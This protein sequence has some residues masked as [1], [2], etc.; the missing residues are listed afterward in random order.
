[1]KLSKYKD[2][3]YDATRSVSSVARTAAFAGIALIWVFRVEGD[4][5]PVIP[6]ALVAPAALLALGLAFDLLQYILAA[7]IWGWFYRH[8]EKKLESPNDD[9][10]ISHPPWYS[11]P[12]RWAFRA[13]V[14]AIMFGYFLVTVYVWRVWFEG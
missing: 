10:D 5:G 7:T 11:L 6:R 14:A 12:I 13:K 3:Y 1:M 4:S 8:E 2:D 9:P